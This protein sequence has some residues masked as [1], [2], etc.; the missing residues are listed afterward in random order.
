[1]TW[2]AVRT[3]K[4][5]GVG[6]KQKDPLASPTATSQNHLEPVQLVHAL[7]APLAMEPLAARGLRRIGIIQRCR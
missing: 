4:F 5:G 7:H 3:V 6:V 1:M 2:L